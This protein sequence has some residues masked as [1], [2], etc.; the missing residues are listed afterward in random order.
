MGLIIDFVGLISFLAIWGVIAHILD[1]RVL[2]IRDFNSRKWDL[3]ISCGPTDGGGLNADIIKRDVPHFVLVKDIYHLPF[4]NK[5]FNNIV[6]SHT[7]EHVDDPD[8]FFKEL[9]RVSKNVTLI[10]PPAWDLAAVAWV[11]EH[12]WQFLTI[13]S[14]HVNEL[15]RKVRLPYWSIQ[16]RLGQRVK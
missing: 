6:C 7:M 9:T 12:K 5:Q 15:P 8:R 1:Y 14:M 13:R 10:I 16:E 3:N 11:L 2:K 4:K